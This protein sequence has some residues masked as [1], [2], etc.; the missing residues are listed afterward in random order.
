MAIVEDDGNGFDTVE[1]ERGGRPQFG[2]AIMRERA[3]SV[4]GHVDVQS[5]PDRGTTVRVEIPLER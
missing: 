3:E 5:S 4:D 1:R 2:L